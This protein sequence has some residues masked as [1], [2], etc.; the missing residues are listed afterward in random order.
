MHS[1]SLRSHLAQVG[2][3]WLHRTLD[4]LQ[5]LHEA[6]SRILV[7]SIVTGQLGITVNNACPLSVTLNT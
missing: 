3:C 5:A 2:F 4:S 6:R 7:S 1:V